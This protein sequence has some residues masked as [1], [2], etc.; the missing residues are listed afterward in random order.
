MQNNHPRFRQLE[1]AYGTLSNRT[2][3]LLSKSIDNLVTEMKNAKNKE[4]E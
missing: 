4:R 1:K 3:I 2:G